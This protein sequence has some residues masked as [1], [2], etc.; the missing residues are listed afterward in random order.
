MPGGAHTR[1]EFSGN[2]K[3]RT[4]TEGL[5]QHG[6]LHLLCSVQKEGEEAR[7]NGRPPETDACVR[8]MLAHAGRAHCS[9][10]RGDI[11]EFDV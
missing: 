11:K 4:E 6:R 1:A 3:N 2:C 10:R 5:C 8:V 9:M 7:T